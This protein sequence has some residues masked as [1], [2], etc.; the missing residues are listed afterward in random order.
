MRS[1][2][3]APWRRLRS[4]W[5]SHPPSSR[6][7]RPTPPTSRSSAPGSPAARPRSRSLA[8]A[9]ACVC[10]TPA[11]SQRGRVAATE[12]SRCVAVPRGMTSREKPMVPMP[13]KSCGGVPRPRSIDSNQWP[14]RRS[15]APAAY[16]SR[17]MTRNV[18]RSWPSTRRCAR[19]VSRRSGATSCRICVR[20]SAARSSIGPT[21]R[22]SPLGSCGVLRGSPRRK[23]SPFSK[24]AALSRWTPSR[25]SRS[26][27][28]PTGPAA[29]YWPSS[30]TQSGRRA[31]RC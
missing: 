6:S 16:A 26:S 22:C 7:R 20:N 15:A 29:D 19:T 14:A 8:A 17:P 13:H 30:T 27:S 2:S 1:N 18:P 5:L 23:E 31:D 11:A 28:Q 4:G 12:G 9:C 24:T 10:T 25:P 3:I 21:A